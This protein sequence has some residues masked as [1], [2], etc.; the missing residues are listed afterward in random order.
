MSARLACRCRTVLAGIEGGRPVV[1]R[2]LVAVD[3]RDELP[4][5]RLP[6]ILYPQ[7]DMPAQLLETV[8]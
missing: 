3:V 2:E 8:G 1:L 6:P 5:R 4:P 7:S